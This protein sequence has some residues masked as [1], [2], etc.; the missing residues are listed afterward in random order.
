MKDPTFGSL[1]WSGGYWEGSVT[2][3]FFRDFGRD[4]S[5]ASQDPTEDPD[6]YDD[7]GEPEVD[8]DPKRK[9]GIVDL[10]VTPAGGKRLTPTDAQRL[11]WK[12][13]QSRGDDAWKELMQKLLETYR[14]QRPARARWW[15]AVYGTHALNQ[16][17]PDL[18]S[19][20][21]LARM[22]APVNVLVQPHAVP[23]AATPDVLVQFAGNWLPGG[24]GAVFRDGR[25]ADF[26]T[27]AAPD[28]AE[29]PVR[30]E[31][32]A[33]GRLGW[34]DHYAAWHAMMR[35]EGLDTFANVAPMR[36][37]FEK[38]RASF[39]NPTLPLE[40]DFIEGRFSTLVHA[41]GV[42]PPTARQAAACESFRATA[43]QNAAAVA[44]AVFKQYRA[45]GVGPRIAA[46]DAMRENLELASVHVYPDDPKDKQ[47]PAIGFV[48]YGP[49]DT[50]FGVRFRDGRVES[51][52][53]SDHAEP[54]HAKDPRK[55]PAQPP[56][57]ASASTTAPTPTRAPTPPAP[58]QKAKAT[59]A[60]PK[61][62]AA[63]R[64]RP[65]GRVGY[66][67]EY[68]A[69]GDVG[70]DFLLHSVHLDPQMHPG[71]TL[72][73]RLD[74]DPAESGARLEAVSAVQDQTLLFYLRR[75]PAIRKALEAALAAQQEDFDPDGQSVR[76]DVW[77]WAR[78]LRL[79]F[80]TP[81]PRRKNP[82]KA[83]F[84]LY[85]DC[86]WEKEHVV[87]ATFEDEKLKPLNLE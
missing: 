87:A 44:E 18:Q 85:L 49:A 61:A 6:P 26:V 36:A 32:A 65:A 17:L 31:H 72:T 5:R 10:L 66:H 59:P 4:M 27:F 68:A 7:D 42:E 74:R 43:D 25:V 37:R 83:A 38:N 64:R 69:D 33:F 22:I 35:W 23:P 81:G 48:F 29:N 73:V 20:D 13:V 84:T 57:S 24:F 28:R 21:A 53:E 34:N 86:D 71:G 76:G 9:Q 30:F 12:H 15:K 3:P 70:V 39:K 16:V 1:D 45:V 52:G 60:E 8:D 14:R 47:P 75:Q 51:V 55:R 41:A 77:T 58:K 2:L 80:I 11:A 46:A 54:R 56:A 19:A 50:S 82:P 79:E 78:L 67:L 63:P 62:A 40:W